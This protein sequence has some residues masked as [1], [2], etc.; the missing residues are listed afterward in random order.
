[1]NDPIIP[2]TETSFLGG[3]RFELG[4]GSAFRVSPELR[5]LQERYLV[6]KNERQHMT[7]ATSCFAMACPIMPLG[8]LAALFLL[9]R[10]DGMDKDPLESMEKGRTLQG[11]M[12]RIAAAH[13]LMRKKKDLGE[14]PESDAYLKYASRELELR[15]LRMAFRPL[16]GEKRVIPK[17]Q[18]SR[19]TLNGAAYFLTKEKQT[20]EREIKRQKIML[21]SIANKEREKNPVESSKINEKLEKLD[22]LLKK[23]GA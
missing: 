11:D 22:Q 15:T 6:A 21:E 5:E 18:Q 23:M 16:K 4:S 10:L 20:K 2:G 17:H 19:D 14:D 7:I 13:A 8:F 1:M 3:G 9:G 12:A